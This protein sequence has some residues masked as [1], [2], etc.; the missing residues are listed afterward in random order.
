EHSIL[1]LPLVVVNADSNRMVQR[2]LTR[3]ASV[4]D[5]VTG[6]ARRRAED[7]AGVAEVVV[8]GAPAKVVAEAISSRIRARGEVDAH[9]AANTLVDHRRVGDG[10][11]PV[12]EADI[13]YKSEVHPADVLARTGDDAL[14]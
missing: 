12:G 14:V 8:V 2:C 10:V 11:D 4:V 7:I 6:R 9:R 3:V 1:I 13:F 5:H